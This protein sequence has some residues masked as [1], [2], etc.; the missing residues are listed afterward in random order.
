MEDLLKEKYIH[1]PKQR[2]YEQDCKELTEIVE[3][4]VVAL[5]SMT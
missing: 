4:C 1:H 2:V 5:I 3:R